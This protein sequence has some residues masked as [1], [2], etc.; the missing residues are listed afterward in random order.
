MSIFSHVTIGANDIAKAKSFYDALLK[1]LGLVRRA[2]YPDAASYGKAEGPTPFWVVRPLDKKP[3]TAGNGITIGLEADEQARGRCRVQGRHGRRR[4]GRRPARRARELQ[5]ELL[6]RLR[7][8]SRRHQDLHR[9]PQ[10]A[11]IDD[12]LR[13]PPRMGQAARGHHRHSGVGGAAWRAKA[14]RCTGRKLRQSVVRDALIVVGDHAIEASLRRQDR[15]HE[16]FA[17]RPFVQKAVLERGARWSSVP[18]G[19]PNEVDGPFLEGGDVL[20][21][22]HEVYVGMS[23]RSSD[24]AGIDWLQALLGARYRVIPVAM[25]SDVLHLE[26]VLALDEARPAAVVPGETDRRAA[27]VAAQLGCNRRIEGRD[28]SASS[29]RRAA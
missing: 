28:R 18:P 5:P 26:D 13:R 21:N 20:L 7:A 6:R 15:Q 1:P 3:A 27:D 8:R 29:S 9:L 23:G 4:H 24:M 11:L 14:S 16:R 2:D 12:A 25:K 17:V 10:G 22:G 19:W